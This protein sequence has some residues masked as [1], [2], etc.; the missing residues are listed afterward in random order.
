[1]IAGTC[2]FYDTVV[3]MLPGSRPPRRLLYGV[4]T[5]IRAYAVTDGRR[6]WTAITFSLSLGGILLN[7]VR[8]SPGL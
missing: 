4:V 1:M 3:R 5:S 2:G 8:L 7:V 6:L